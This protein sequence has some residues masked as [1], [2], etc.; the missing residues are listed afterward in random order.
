MHTKKKKP[1]CKNNKYY[2]GT[3]KECHTCDVRLSC[4]SDKL[5]SKE[6][7]QKSN[8]SLQWWWKKN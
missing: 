3:H 8:T 6:T 5:F 4:I 1:S 7:A 2:K